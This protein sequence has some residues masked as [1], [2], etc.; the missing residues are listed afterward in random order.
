MIQEHNMRICEL[1]KV[2]FE[3][4][5]KIYMVRFGVQFSRNTWVKSVLGMGSNM[6]KAENR[7]RILR[8]LT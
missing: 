8:G 5:F 2:A 6:D 1:K 3:M 4:N 7:K